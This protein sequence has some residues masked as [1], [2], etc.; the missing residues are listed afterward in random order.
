MTAMKTP[1][2]RA[3]GKRLERSK[4][5]SSDAVAP[6]AMNTAV[7]PTTKSAAATIVRDR[8]AGSS[9]PSPVR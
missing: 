6:S 3:T 1:A 4:K 5:P 8:R 2:T 7:K 9:P